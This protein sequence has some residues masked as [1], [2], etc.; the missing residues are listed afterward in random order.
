MEV[1]KIVFDGL[2][3][4]GTLALAAVTVWLIL[5]ARHARK[6]ERLGHQRTAFR[7]ALVEQLENCR[8]WSAASTGLEGPVERLQGWEPSFQAL[9]RLLG[10]V[11]VPGELAAYLVWAIAMVREDNDRAQ[12]GAAPMGPENHWVHE[13]FTPAAILA[14]LE[15]LQTTACLLA[16]E[17]R[18]RGFRDIAEAF[19][20]DAPWLLWLHPRIWQSGLRAST[21]QGEAVILFGPGLPQDSAYQ[22]CLPEARDH[23]AQQ[24]WGQQEAALY[25]GHL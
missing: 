4:L 8:P 22:G 25:Q 14:I 21:A 16:C 5:D 3:A 20:Q 1:L 23:L 6:E 7:A 15:R 10:T 18:R 24:L 11:D 2:V 9:S 12:P 13:G 19:P 17:A